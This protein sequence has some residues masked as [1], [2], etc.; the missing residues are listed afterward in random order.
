MKSGWLNVFILGITATLMATPCVYATDGGFIW[1]KGMG[2]TGDENGISVLVDD[3]GN[4][5]VAGYFY[6]TMDFDPGPGV[7]ELVSAG[8]QDGF[9]VKLDPAGNLLWAKGIGHFEVSKSG[10]LLERGLFD[11]SVWQTN[12]IDFAAGAKC[13]DGLEQ[14]RGDPVLIPGKIKR[15]DS[16]N[17]IP[18]PS[19]EEMAK[20]EA[21]KAK[22]KA[23]MSDEAQKKRHE[24]SEARVN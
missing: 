5:Y 17:T 14:R 2:G 15:L 19:P 22:A 7:F 23:E 4:L 16:L 3:A 20:A 9:I 1:A 11:G 12:R 18:D 10:S 8:G 24:W 21:N 13:Y 6:G